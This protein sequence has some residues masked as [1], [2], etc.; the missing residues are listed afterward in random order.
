[1]SSPGTSP[2][3]GRAL[4]VCKDA[5]SVQSLSEGMHRLAIAFDVC[6]DVGLALRILNRKK[7]EAVIVDLGLQ[8]AEQ[9]LEQVRLSA[10]NRT[11]VTFAIIAPRAPV[12]FPTQPNFVLEKPLSAGVVDRTLKA[13][14]GLIVRERRRYFRCPTAIP[15]AIQRDGKEESCHLANISEGGVALTELPSLK[16]GAQVTV[17]FT[18]PGLLFRFVVES[19]VCW[20]DENGRAGLRWLAIPFEHQSALQG[21][22]AAKLEEDF[23]ESVARQFSKKK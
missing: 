5:A 6:E 16:P 8:Q 17:L 12:T 14:F 10:S 7:F 15:A 4:L 21:W 23:P 3:M 13:A 22:L 9:V 1:M 11:A 18:L 19:E 2:S 20:Y